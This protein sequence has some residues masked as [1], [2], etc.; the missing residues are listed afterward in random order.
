VKFTPVAKHLAPIS[1]DFMTVGPKLLLRSA[2][3]SV[4]TILAYVASGFA[5]VRPNLVHVAAN[6][7]PVGAY[8]SAIRTQLSAFRRLESTTV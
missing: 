6:L 3:A 4:L 2:F 7:S 8:L 5:P 1:S